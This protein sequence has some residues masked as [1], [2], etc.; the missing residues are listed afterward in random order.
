[1]DLAASSRRFAREI[2]SRG[3]IERRFEMNTTQLAFALAI[4]AAM[5]GAASAQTG[6][7]PGAADRGAPASGIASPAIPGNSTAGTT[8]A[9]APAGAPAT[10][11]PAVAATH[12]LKAARLSKLDGVDIYDGN[13]KKIGEVKDLVVDPDSG[14]VLHALVSLGGVMGIGDKEYAVPT[15]ELRVFSRAADDSL[16]AKVELGTPQESLNQAKKMEKDSPYLMGSKLVGMDINDASGKEIGEVEDVIVDLQSGEAQYALV[17]FEDSWA[18]DNKLF[19][20]RMTELKRDKDGRNL[21]LN[22]TKEG[23]GSLP[24]I[25]SGRLDKV[26]LSNP[27]WIQQTGATTGTSGGNAPSR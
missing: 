14:R 26:D 25:E 20:F 17:E 13:A 5:S 10:A 9:T 3:R 11:S 16:P 18:P 23:L 12:E 1:M 8:S 19:A 6:A 7:S 4:S 22:V 21:V 24:A 2:L 15:K 27:S